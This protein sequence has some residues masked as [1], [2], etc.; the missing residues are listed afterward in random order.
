MPPFSQLVVQE[1]NAEK[2]ILRAERDAARGAVDDA[3]AEAK[4][5][6]AQERAKFEAKLGLL[7]HRLCT[8]ISVQKKVTA[9]RDELR[10]MYK[11]AE[12]SVSR[13][14]SKAKDGR[15]SSAATFA[16]SSSVRVW[17]DSLQL[18]R[19]STSG[20]EGLAVL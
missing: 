16:L 1:S 18:P 2:Q 3:V 6:A 8:A 20:R 11:R 7:R 12:V 14:S 9:E 19:P 10:K 17:R 4:A 15:P 5:E 13:Q